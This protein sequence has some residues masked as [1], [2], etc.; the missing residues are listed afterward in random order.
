[1]HSKMAYER[2]QQIYKENLQI[3]EPCSVSSLSGSI[4]SLNKISN[5]NGYVNDPDFLLLFLRREKFDVRKTA[6]RLVNF[7]ELVYELWGE[8]ALTEKTWQS[9]TNLDPFEREV[10]RTGIMQVL[11]GRDR[12][13][14]RILGNF[15]DDSSKLTVENRVSFVMC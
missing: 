11:Q 9:Q 3:Q 2:S 13:G 14:R 12:A 15:A 4:S 8:K 7:M 10:L 6:L 1:M 5:P